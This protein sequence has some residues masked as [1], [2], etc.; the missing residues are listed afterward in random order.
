M[1]LCRLGPGA[2]GTSPVR[3][4]KR[5]AIGADVLGMDEIERE[6]IAGMTVAE[7]LRDILRI[8]ERG[9]GNAPLSPFADDGERG[10]SYPAGDQA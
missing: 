6:R 8:L 4:S 7:S 10:V 3:S 1:P 9:R 2:A 5:R